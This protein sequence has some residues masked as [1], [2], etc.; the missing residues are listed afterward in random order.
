MLVNYA[1]DANGRLQ[2]VT[3]YPFNAAK[4]T[5]TLSED[6]DL[7]NIRDYVL[8]DGELIHEPYEPVPTAAELTETDYI[9]AK[10]VD[11]L[12]G[13]ESL[14]ALL[15]AL[16]ETRS[17][18]QEILD[19]RGVWRQQIRELEAAESEQNKEV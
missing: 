9:A 19:L 11:L 6:F 4:P 5:L 15:T 18:Y 1:T 2:N 10:T 3:I 17:E 16:A 8:K 7:K 13:A 14:S 12:I